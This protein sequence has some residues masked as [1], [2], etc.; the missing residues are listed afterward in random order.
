VKGESGQFQD[1]R[2]SPYVCPVVGIKF[3]EKFKFVYLWKCG[4]VISKRALK[5]APS[6]FCHKCQKP[7]KHEDIV[8]FNS[9]EKTL[10][11]M[12]KQTE[13]QKGKKIKKIK[14]METPP[15]GTTSTSREP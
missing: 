13:E 10:E 7:F 9:D 12:K 14:A 11:L 3:S 2:E 8:Y 1:P 4:C 15:S 6:E 5:L